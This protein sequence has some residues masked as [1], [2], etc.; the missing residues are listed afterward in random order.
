[1]NLRDWVAGERA[2]ERARGAELRLRETFPQT[3]PLGQAFPASPIARSRRSNVPPVNVTRTPPYGRAISVACTQTFVEAGTA[4]NWSGT[5]ANLRTAGFTSQTFPNTALTIPIRAYWRLEVTV[6]WD[7]YLLGGRVEVFRDGTLLWSDQAPYGA[8]F[9]RTFNLG[10]CFPDEDIVVEVSPVGQAGVQPDGKQATVVASLVLVE[11]PVTVAVEPPGEVIT[12]HQTA[13]GN[14]TEQEFTLVE[15]AQEGDAALV[16]IA[17]A[18][19][20]NS[21]G[22]VTHQVENFPIADNEAGTNPQGPDGERL[23]SWRWAGG[24]VANGTFGRHSLWWVPITSQIVAQGHIKFSCTFTGGVQ[25]AH[26]GGVLGV[27]VPGGAALTVSHVGAEG[28]GS[29]QL[30]GGLVTVGLQSASHTS[31]PEE[32]SWVIDPARDPLDD[33]GIYVFNGGGTVWATAGGPDGLS[34]TGGNGWRTRHM[35][36]WA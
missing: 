31:S 25:S 14:N 34:W 36:G 28:A 10:V 12:W 23:W 29:V 4:C 18:V 8:T 30:S 2:R 26:G 33:G 6:A 32:G 20:T 7:D 3:G 1:M 27:L 22:V 19:N 15:G 35:V 9:D 24:I 16:C 5:V 21:S 13:S 17:T 11:L